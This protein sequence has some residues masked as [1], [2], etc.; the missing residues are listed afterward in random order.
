MGDAPKHP[1]A[2]TPE[3]LAVR[4]AVSAATVR[5]LIREGKLRSF[6]VG[7]QMRIRPQWV[8]EFEAAGEASGR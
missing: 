5:N 6:S 3:T 1:Y 7:R 4:W 8:E 2:Y